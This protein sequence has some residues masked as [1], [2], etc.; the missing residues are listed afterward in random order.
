MKKFLL[1]IVLLDLLGILPLPLQAREET[2][3]SPGYK[4]TKVVD[5]DTL[6]V[7]AGKKKT[8]IRLIG[9][10]TPEKHESD[11]L[12]RDSQRTGQ[13]VKTIRA[14]GKKSSD[15]TKKLLKGRPVRLEFDQEKTDVYG[16]TLAYV[17]FQPK[18]NPPPEEDLMLNRVLVESGYAHAYSKFPF[19][20]REEFIELER[21]ARE[22][23]RGL[24]AP[25][26]KQQTLSSQFRSEKGP[27]SR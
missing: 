23:A 19:R 11:K 27:I 9:V 14:L 22:A 15:F 12:Y 24:W 6:I 20:Y 2:A 4:V 18:G 8:T 26:S 5:G 7:K 21:M 25:N 1:V 13:E 3:D 16:R 10:D 17:Y